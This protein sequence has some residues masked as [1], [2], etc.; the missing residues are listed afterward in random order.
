ML[1]R[2]VR[3]LIPIL[4]VGIGLGAA[5]FY[6]SKRA[7]DPTADLPKPGEG[8]GPA[9]VS[10]QEQ[11]ER[12]EE[13]LRAMEETRKLNEQARPDAS[14]LPPTNPTA[15][16]QKTFKTLEEINRLNRLNREMREKQQSSPNR[17]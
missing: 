4:I 13:T 10:D 1:K 17:R 5:Y 9:V 3:I 16:L 14:P 7:A 2:V 12:L 11:K 15:D 6:W 8:P